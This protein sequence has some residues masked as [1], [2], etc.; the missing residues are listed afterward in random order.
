MDL[1]GVTGRS[2]PFRPEAERARAVVT[3][4]IGDSTA[5]VEVEAVELHDLVP[6]RGEVLGELL[7]RVL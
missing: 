6:G 2:S 7:L 4:G 5:S 3:P 1:D